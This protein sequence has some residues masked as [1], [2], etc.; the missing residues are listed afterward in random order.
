MSSKQTPVPQAQSSSDISGTLGSAMDYAID[1]AQR[2][3]LF[4]DVMRQR[5]NQ[6]REHLA[7]TVPHVLSSPRRL[8]RP[9]LR[10]HRLPPA[11]G[12][13]EAA[14]GDVIVVRMGSG[15]WDLPRSMESPWAPV[16]ARSTL[17]F[18]SI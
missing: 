5:G 3:V 2:T 13:A 14:A 16:R 10:S 18:C 17:A 15:A 12:R 6:Y 9:L 8:S 1:A 7:E 4:W 11:G